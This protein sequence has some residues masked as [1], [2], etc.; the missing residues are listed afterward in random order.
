LH[1]MLMNGRKSFGWW[2]SQTDHRS[3]TANPL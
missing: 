3:S 1:S 2:W